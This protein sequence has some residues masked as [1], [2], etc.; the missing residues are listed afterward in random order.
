MQGPLVVK[1]LPEDVDTL[2]DSLIYLDYNGMLDTP[3]GLELRRLLLA[4]LAQADRQRGLD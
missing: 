4:V 1:L 2:K 3:L